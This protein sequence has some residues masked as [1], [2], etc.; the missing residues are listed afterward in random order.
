MH[1]YFFTAFVSEKTY[2]FKVIQG[3]SA[4]CL[5]FLLLLGNTTLTFICSWISF[6]AHFLYYCSTNH[7]DDYAGPNWTINTASKADV[8]RDCDVIL[9]RV[10]STG[11]KTGTEKWPVTD[12]CL[13]LCRMF[14]STVLNHSLSCLYVLLFTILHMCASIHTVC[15]MFYF[16]LVEE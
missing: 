16:V 5:A 8:I 12:Q 6:L 11:S 9:S 13:L 10:C 3:T 14:A 1:L 15:W 2:D 4:E 7:W